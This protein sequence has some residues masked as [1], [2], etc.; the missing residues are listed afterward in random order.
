MLGSTG[1]TLTTVTDT[2]TNAIAGIPPVL[3]FVGNSNITPITLATLYASYPASST[4]NGYYARVSNLFN[5]TSTSAAGGLD[6]LV[7]CRYDVTNATYSWQPQ[8]P[9]YNLTSS[10]TSGTITLTPLVSPP[11]LR[12]AG[13]LI[14]NLTVTPSTTNAYIGQRF[15]VIQN[16]TLGLFTTSITGLI[17]SNITLLGNNVQDLEYTITGWMKAST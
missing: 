14:G 8:R 16:S 11:T 7:R 6:E 2:V 15:R 10:S 4:Y 9:E 17:G 3:Q 1:V 12:L 5:G 13:T